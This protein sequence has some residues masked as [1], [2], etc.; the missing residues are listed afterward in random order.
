MLNLHF[1]NCYMCPFRESQPGTDKYE[2]QKCRIPPENKS[3]ELEEKHMRKRPSWCMLYKG[4]YI[5]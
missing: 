1:H 2:R 4:V 5:D 3:G